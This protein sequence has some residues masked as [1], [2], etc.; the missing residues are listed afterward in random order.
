M[1]VHAYGM[2][3]CEI[4]PDSPDSRIKCRVVSGTSNLVSRSGTLST[5]HHVLLGRWLCGEI[6]VELHLAIGVGDG[7][8]ASRLDICGISLQLGVNS[9][10]R[11]VFSIYSIQESRV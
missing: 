10:N 7:W 4:D 9:N 5:V 1:G 11:D 3:I 2:Y 6:A 8:R